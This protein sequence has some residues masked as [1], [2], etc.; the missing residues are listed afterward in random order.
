MKNVSK[1]VI[2]RRAWQ[3]RELFQAIDTA[4]PAT[5]GAGETIIVLATLGRGLCDELERYVNGERDGLM[6]CG[7]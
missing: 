5:V 3:L 7:S 4:S 1:D 6:G 2:M